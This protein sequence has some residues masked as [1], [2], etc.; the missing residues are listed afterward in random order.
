L[1]G[2]LKVMSYDLALANPQA[3]YSQCTNHQ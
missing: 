1:V 2:A 3:R